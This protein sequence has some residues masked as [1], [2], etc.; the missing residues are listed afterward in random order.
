MANIPQYA[1]GELRNTRKEVGFDLK[2]WFGLP[3]IQ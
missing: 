1:D 2:T 3:T